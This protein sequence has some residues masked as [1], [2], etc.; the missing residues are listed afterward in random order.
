MKPE[1]NGPVRCSELLAHIML[2]PPPVE[3]WTG[4]QKHKAPANEIEQRIQS[5]VPYERS[6]TS[7]K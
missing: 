6:P 7:N 2:V 4:R 3:K 1:H 5:K